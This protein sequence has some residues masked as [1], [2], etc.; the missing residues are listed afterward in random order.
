MRIEV[1]LFKALSWGQLSE[2]VK[3]FFIEFLAGAVYLSVMKK[4]D[5]AYR[6]I[7]TLYA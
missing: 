1:Q 4:T 6:I 2:L 7:G 3:I 5:D